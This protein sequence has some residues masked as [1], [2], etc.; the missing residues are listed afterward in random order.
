MKTKTILIILITVLAVISLVFQSCQKDEE[1]NNELPI[2][3]FTD[4]RDGQIYNI[5]DIGTQTWFAE[6]LNYETSNSWWYDN[7]SANGDVYGRLYTWDAALTVCPDGWHLPTD[8]EWIV[9]TTYLGEAVA[10][11]KMKETGTAHWNSPNIGATNSS[12]FTAL[13]WGYRGSSGL[14]SGL[15]ASG[16]WWSSSERSGTGAWSRYLYYDHGQVFRGNYYKAYGFS[17]RCLK[18]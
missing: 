9:I 16:H 1:K 7:N 4:P 6:N 3:T 12:G 11:G 15:G 2:C 10:G 8:D 18:N 13:P 17:V 5:V 14:F